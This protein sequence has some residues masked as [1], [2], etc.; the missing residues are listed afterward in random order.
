MWANWVVRLRNTG[1]A[2]G[3]VQASIGDES[4]DLAWIV[5]SRWLP[6]AKTHPRACGGSQSGH[7]RS[8]LSSR[9]GRSVPVSPPAGQHAGDLEE[10]VG[11][12]LEPN[13]PVADA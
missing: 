4:A 9:G 6:T 3:Y 12:A 7:E 5:G 11:V 2:I 1:E 8:V 10:P 13:A